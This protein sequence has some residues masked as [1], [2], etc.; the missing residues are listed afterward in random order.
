MNNLEIITNSIVQTINE[1]IIDDLLNMNFS[2][3]EAV[4]MV[5][6]FEFDLYEDSLTLSDSD[7]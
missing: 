1:G 3:D 2:H 7:F 4:K 6:E 5:T